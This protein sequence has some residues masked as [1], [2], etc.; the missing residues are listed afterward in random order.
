MHDFSTLSKAD[1]EVYSSGDTGGTT[2]LRKPVL[3]QMVGIDRETLPISIP[4]DISSE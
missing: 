2:R 3:R 4:K 1:D